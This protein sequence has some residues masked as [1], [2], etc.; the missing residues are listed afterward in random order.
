MEEQLRWA[1]AV[2]LNE[3]PPRRAAPRRSTDAQK[4][5]AHTNPSTLASPTPA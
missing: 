5:H 2:A 1:D 4:Q 3:T